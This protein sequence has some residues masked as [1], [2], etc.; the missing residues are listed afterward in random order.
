MTKGKLAQIAATLIGTV[1]FTTVNVGVAVAPARAVE[2]GG[3]IMLA[4]AIDTD[5]A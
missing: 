2:T 4:A 5:Q 1:I 3:S